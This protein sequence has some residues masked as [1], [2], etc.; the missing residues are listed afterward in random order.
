[1]AS[2]TSGRSPSASTAAALGA[3]FP[4]D[5]VSGLAG[6]FG[7]SAAFLSASLRFLRSFFEGRGASFCD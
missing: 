3:S 2:S 7:V 1:M 6:S 5:F 4:W